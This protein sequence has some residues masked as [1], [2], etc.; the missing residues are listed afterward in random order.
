MEKK[1][2]NNRI[3]VCIPGRQF[4]GNFLD[5]WTQ[6]FGSLLKNGFQV[7]LSREYTCT[8]PIVRHKCLGVSG[9]GPRRKTLFNGEYDYILWIDSDQIFLPK[10]FEYLYA[11][12]EGGLEVVSGYY[13]YADLSG[14]A[15]GWIEGDDFKHVTRETGELMKKAK[16][17]NRL[18]ACDWV[19]MGFMLIKKG[20]FERIDYPYFA[21][22]E[23]LMQEGTFL[24]VLGEDLYFGK[25]LKDA[26]IPIHVDPRVRVGHEKMTIL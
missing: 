18:V 6:L 21:H 23:Q 25:K 22:P 17:E 2:R 11:D 1:L 12:A 26:G 19:G 13:N 4:S 24:D 16:D 14:C 10:H 20:V 5:C 15:L 9:F 3:V 8:L 7:K